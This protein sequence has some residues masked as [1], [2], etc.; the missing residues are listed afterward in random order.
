LK[1]CVLLD[2]QTFLTPL[3]FP[4]FCLD[5][6][7]EQF[8]S[9]YFDWMRFSV[10]VLVNKSYMHQK[11]KILAW[12]LPH[13]QRATTKVLREDQKRQNGSRRDSQETCSKTSSVKFFHFWKPTTKKKKVFQ[14]CSFIFLDFFNDSNSECISRVQ[15]LINPHMVDIW[16]DH[17]KSDHTRNKKKPVRWCRIFLSVP[18]K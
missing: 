5:T 17:V 6:F 16:D 2:S 8:A 4:F 10:K 11:K 12:H 1:N 7:F 18:E 14:T 9:I 3:L 15:N 13:L